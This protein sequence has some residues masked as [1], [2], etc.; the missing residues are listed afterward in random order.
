MH[1]LSIVP[2]VSCFPV[3]FWIIFA[4]CG[5]EE[6]ASCALLECKICAN[7]KKK[8]RLQITRRVFAILYS[9]NIPRGFHIRAS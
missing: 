3:K 8:R 5:A 9:R 1:T 2:F 6:G 4:V 7:A